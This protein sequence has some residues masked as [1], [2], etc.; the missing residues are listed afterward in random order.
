MSVFFL[1]IFTASAALSTL[2]RCFFIVFWIFSTSCPLYM[3]YKGPKNTVFLQIRAKRTFTTNAW[4]FV[5]LWFAY[6]YATILEYWKA[7]K[8]K[9]QSQN[10]TVLLSR[11][12]TLL[13]EERLLAFGRGP[14]IRWNTSFRTESTWE[15]VDFDLSGFGTQGWLFGLRVTSGGLR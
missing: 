7:H 11:C 8:V 15:R 2:S 6:R 13:E 10:G 3:S 9:A 5:D 14:G 1:N 12:L 4:A